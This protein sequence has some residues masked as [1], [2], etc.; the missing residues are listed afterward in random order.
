MIW[1]SIRLKSF[2]YKHILMPSNP[3]KRS[4]HEIDDIIKFVWILHLHLLTCI[5][6]LCII[7]LE[8][9]YWNELLDNSQS[10]KGIVFSLQSLIFFQT[11][12]FALCFILNTII[13]LG[14]N[15]MN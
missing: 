2:C 6:S 7:Y 5:P 1:K 11:I 14:D 13:F 10:L 12:H 15:Q 4:L 8:K 9:S 3:Y